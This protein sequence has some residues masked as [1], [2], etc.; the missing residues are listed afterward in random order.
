[1]KAQ[2]RQV[3][4]TLVV[5]LLGSGVRSGMGAA[6]APRKHQELRVYHIGNSVTDAIHYKSLQQ[7]AKANGDN[8]VYG[9]HMIPGAPLQFIWD[10]P[11][12]GFKENPYGYYPSALKDYEWDV[13]TLQPFDRQLDGKDGFGDLTH[14]KKFIDL[15]LPKSP[16]VQVYVYERWPRRKEKVK[17]NPSSGYEPFD[18]QAQWQRKY[19][20]KWDGSNE[21][22]NYFET[23]T[24]DLREAYP[25]LEKPVLMIPVGEVLFELDKRVKAGK[26]PGLES[27]EDLYVDGIHFNNVGAF[28]AGTTF[29]ATMFK[30]DPRGTDARAYAPGKS[31]K[32][33]PIAPELAKAVQETVWEVVSTHPLAGVKKDD[34]A[35]AGA[36]DSDALAPA[37][38]SPVSTPGSTSA[39]KNSTSNSPRRAAPRKK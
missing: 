23:L 34:S 11:E 14:C 7:L 36:A 20:A 3:V 37:A 31:E 2:V 24:K 6:A 32:D 26:V 33:K 18:Y 21:T 27:I 38:K 4:A 30:T 25:K 12:T 22:R 10:K 1:M 28:I 16:G 15:A 13:I 29:Y 17:K 8:Y 19:T 39:A 9:R 35:A 5:L